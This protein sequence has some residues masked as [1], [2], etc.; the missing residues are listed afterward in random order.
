MMVMMVRGQ[1]SVFFWSPMKFVHRVAFLVLLLGALSTRP[2]R[3]PPAANPRLLL[4]LPLLHTL[5]AL[6]CVF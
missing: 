2:V 3:A 4:S 6:Q 5:F 1:E